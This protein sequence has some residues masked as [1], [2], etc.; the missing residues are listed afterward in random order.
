MKSFEGKQTKLFM[1]QVSLGF[2]KLGP[3][4]RRNLK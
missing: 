3:S 1:L 4:A 2:I